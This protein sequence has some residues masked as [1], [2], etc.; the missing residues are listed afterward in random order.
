MEGKVGKKKNK[1]DT[2]YLFLSNI[3]LMSTVFTT[4]NLI[5]KMH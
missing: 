2:K 1:L 4:T 5:K 3:N